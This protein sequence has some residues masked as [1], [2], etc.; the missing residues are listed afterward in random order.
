VAAGQAADL[1][2]WR[3]SAVCWRPSVHKSCDA[4]Y[5]E[6]QRRELWPRCA[7]R[8]Q[9]RGQEEAPTWCKPIMAPAVAGPGPATAAAA[10]GLVM[11]MSGL[12]ATVGMGMLAE[13]CCCR[14][15]CCCCCCCSGGVA[16]AEVGGGW[17]ALEAGAL[18]GCGGGMQWRQW[19]N[20]P[21]L[22]GALTGTAA[23]SDP[24]LGSRQPVGPA[25]QA[26]RSNA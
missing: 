21:S 23:S 8:F 7:G 26:R 24:S 17:M 10:V 4:Q 12:G 14:C 6:T 15:C 13:A 19:F 9:F 25:Q 22:A 11:D 18:V 16:P 20:A 3:S 5:T 1:Q 2:R